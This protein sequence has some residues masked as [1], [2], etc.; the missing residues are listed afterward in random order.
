[1]GVAAMS[2]V[3]RGETWWLD[4]QINGARVRESLKTTDKRLAQQAHDIR[5]AELWRQG[6]LREKPR[7]TWQQAG[8]RWLR[9]KADK[10][11]IELDRLKLAHF[12]ATFAS[13]PLSSVTADMVEDCCQRGQTP[14]TRNRYRALARAILR[15][16]EREW[17]WIDRAPFI[18]MEAENNARDKCLT[19]EQLSALLDALPAS[20][21]P[22]VRFAVLT[23]LRRANVLEL[24]W[25]AVNLDAA[26]V[27]VSSD[28][29]KSG[30]RIVV[31]LNAQAVA[32]LAALPHREG[33]VFATPVSYRV[34]QTACRKAGL[35]D[36]RFHDLRH[37]WA[38][39]HAMAG[40]DMQVL[41]RLGGWSSPA[42]L[43][44]YVSLAPAHL[45]TAAERV[46]L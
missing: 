27:V 32:V 12:N 26:T 9:E 13:I 41:Q 37:T 8:E 4:C 36:F 10:R 19:R 28:D 34:W 15:A 21:A 24:D 2:L 35:E 33:R 38:S 11:S 25:S 20:Y 23:G 31:P 40:T 42:M 46:T 30:K 44:R 6:V 22:I 43:Q 39:W 29:S 14:A 18:R 7:K 3:L 5:R 17:E 45:A 1:M 16:A